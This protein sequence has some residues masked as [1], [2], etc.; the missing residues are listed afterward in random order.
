MLSQGVRTS[1]HKGVLAMFGLHLVE[2]G[3][4]DSN[5]AKILAKEKE[6][7]EL[8]DYDVMIDLDEERAE[9]RIRQAEQFVSIVKS[10]LL[11][12]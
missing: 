1:S 11:K 5:L 6:E 10:F 4:L 2:K 9:E 8:G 3:L 12:S 7:R